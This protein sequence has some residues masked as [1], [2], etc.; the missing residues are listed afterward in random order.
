MFAFGEIKRKANKFVQFEF[1]EEAVLT[2]MI[3]TT[4]KDFGL[5]SFRLRANN[6]PNSPQLL[7]VK[8]PIAYVV[9]S[10]NRIW[11]EFTSEY[12]C[13][14]FLHVLVGDH[15]RLQYQNGKQWRISAAD[16]TLLCSLCNNKD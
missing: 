8:D 15:G 7:T 9:R 16:N 3:V 6:D 4:Y 11:I 1:H 12:F 14:A 13:L 5:K 2:G 10:K